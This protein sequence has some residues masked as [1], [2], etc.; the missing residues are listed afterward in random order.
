MANDSHRSHTVPAFTYRHVGVGGEGR[1]GGDIKPGVFSPSDPKLAV[2]V[3][4]CLLSLLKYVELILH[5]SFLDARRDADA[6]GRRRCT[7]I[8]LPYRSYLYVMLYSICMTR[9]SIQRVALSLDLV[10][11]TK[12]KTSGRCP[13]SVS[14]FSES[15]IQARSLRASTLCW[16]TYGSNDRWG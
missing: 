5:I 2:S 7:M 3:F 10:V 12:V 1:A 16:D 15:H 6:S 14:A 9:Y 13:C 8:Q 11:Y 4:P